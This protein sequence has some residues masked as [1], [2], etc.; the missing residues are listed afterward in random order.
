MVV[1]VVVV[2]VVTVVVVLVFVLV[3]ISVIISSSNLLQVHHTH[4]CFGCCS[5]HVPTIGTPFQ[6]QSVHLTHST[7]SSGTLKHT[8]FQAAFSTPSG[9]LQHPQFT[10]VTNGAL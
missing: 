9:K 7:L 1:I 3:L 8:F 5:F 2:V 10:C 6:T 4:L